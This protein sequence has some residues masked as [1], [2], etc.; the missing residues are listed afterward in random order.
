MLK[1]P[2]FM[3]TVFIFFIQVARAQKEI[4]LPGHDAKPYYFGF[5]VGG[6]ISRY[7]ASLHSS[8]LMNDSISVAEP[9]NS[10]GFNLGFLTT[11]SLSEHFQ[12]R[13]N[14][15]LIFTSRSIFY[16]LKYSETQQ[17]GV[18][19]KVE[20]I[21][22]S[23]PLQVKMQSDR[24]GNFRFYILAGI[25]GSLD[26]N[27]GIRDKK[28]EASLIIKKYDYGPELGLGFNLF[29]PSFILSPEIKVS[30]GVGNILSRDP[31]LKY[32][33]VFDKIQSRM[34]VF[35]LHIEG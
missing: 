22:V 10:T 28:N 29:F 26:V 16:Q 25:Q 20:S 30:N 35:C 14:P 33:S 15:Q 13:I 32:S 3:L 17:T 9:L 31:N 19:K 23:L 7:Q 5:T 27:S 21:L 34:I 4:N 18:T 8:Y 12:L 2:A 1:M 6:N 11:A 24:I